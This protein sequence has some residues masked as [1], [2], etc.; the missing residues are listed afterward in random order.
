MKLVK[1]V[2]NMKKYIMKPTRLTQAMAAL[3][4]LAVGYSAASIAADTAAEFEALKQADT[5][6]GFFEEYCT[7]CHNFDDYSGSLDR[8]RH[9]TIFEKHG[10][11]M[12]C[13]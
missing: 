4:L 13:P 9:S 2:I 1:L 7:S 5:E 12:E 10:D 3:A 8:H 11:L 6:W